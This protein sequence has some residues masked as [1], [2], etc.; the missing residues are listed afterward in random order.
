[1][2]GQRGLL[3]GALVRWLAD[4][5]CCGPPP[6]VSARYT[7]SGVPD[8]VNFERAFEAVRQLAQAIEEQRADLNEAETRLRLIDRLLFD[9]LGWSAHSTAVEH[10]HEGQYADYVLEEGLPVLVVEAKRTGTTFELPDGMPRVAKLETLFAATATFRPV[11]KQALEYALERGVPFAAVSNGRQLVAFLASRQDG[12]PPLEGRALVFGSPNELVDDFRTLWDNLSRDACHSR[13][14]QATLGARPAV[15]PPPKLSAQLPGYPGYQQRSTIATELQILGE[16]FLLDLIQDEEL[17][18]KFL[19]ECYSESGALSQYAAISRGILQSRY[20]AALGETLE[21]RLEPARS[22]KGVSKTLAADV[23]AAAASRRP[24]IL[25]GDVGVGKTIF[26]RHLIRIDAKDIADNALLIYVNLGEQPALAE[27]REFVTRH[28]IEELRTEYDVDI[29]ENAFV[30][31]VYR[32]ELKAFESGIY[33]PLRTSDPDGY[34][35]KEIAELEDRIRQRESHLRRSLAE[36][37]TTR[38]KQVIMIFDNVDQRPSAFQ[39]EAFLLATTLASTWPGT[40]FI[41]LRPETF[42]QSRKDG[43]L[44]AYQPRVFTIPPPRIDRVLAKRIEYGRNQLRATG[45]LPTFPPQVT[46]EAAALRA[47]S[48]FS[49]SRLVATRRLCG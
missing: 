9:C 3:G 1:M 29:F 40:V 14:L 17:E 10:H 48:T 22:R 24:I 33:G 36:L 37:S 11:V 13:R 21:V 43:T 38:R 2:N 25:L 46:L 27:L 16:L 41:T 19:E 39:E 47:I 42:Y 49:C 4:V 7:V 32:R 35:V 26:L 30:R 20:S 23:T 12:V 28:F 18:I 6:L 31:R 5:G 45:R 34:L 8:G 44:T 15:P